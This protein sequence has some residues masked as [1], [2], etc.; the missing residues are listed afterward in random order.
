LTDRTP[1]NG[2]IPRRPGLLQAAILIAAVIAG[3]MPMVIGPVL[4]AI[5]RHFSPAPGVALL[6]PML[7]TTPS[8]ITALLAGIM[9]LLS[10]KWGRRRLLIAAIILY[11]L[12]GTAPLYL[13]NLPLIVA[14]RALVG[15][16]EAGAMTVSTIM[17]GD[18]FSGQRRDRIIAAQTT[19]A[20]VSGIAISLMGGWLGEWGWR[21]PFLVYGAMV[22]LLPPMLLWLWEPA[23][24]R[25]QQAAPAHLQGL[26]TPGFIGALAVSFLIGLGL[27][28]IPV[29]LAYMLGE[30]GIGDPAA[31][32]RVYAM[33]C[34]GT[35]SGTLLFAHGLAG[36]TAVALQFALCA[37]LCAIGTA[38]IGQ[39][40]TLWALTGW[41]V[42]TSLGI[43]ISLPAGTSW[44]LG[45][46]SPAH[47]GRGVGLYMAAQFIGAFISPLIVVPLALWLHSYAKAVQTSAWVFAPLAAYALLSQPA[48]RWRAR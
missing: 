24:A 18:Y 29:N 23:R 6:V 11:G 4:P 44:V 30:A 39:A 22:L 26:A 42:L 37:A 35:V 47:R 19:L 46:L 25:R 36:R 1:A 16:A 38:A 3:T 31:A 45:M 33:A 7:V 17:I 41:S 2:A 12:A 43:G 8:L 21:G 5:Q 20:S 32:G 10:D 14:T 15:V 9:G 28:L 13:D 40:H 27:M 34:L 48:L